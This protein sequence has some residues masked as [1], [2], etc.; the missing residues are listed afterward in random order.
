MPPNSGPPKI[1]LMIFVSNPKGTGY[2]SP[3]HTLGEIPLTPDGLK[4][5]KRLAGSAQWVQAGPQRRVT[6]TEVESV[7]DK[8]SG[9]AE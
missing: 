7:V 4:L 1:S 6:W 3:Y 8:H 5:V 2:Q 9:E